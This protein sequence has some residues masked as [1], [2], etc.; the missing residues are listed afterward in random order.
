LDSDR[1]IERVLDKYI[2]SLDNKDKMA[3]SITIVFCDDFYY[4][5]KLEDIKSILYWWA[6]I[7]GF[8]IVRRDS[9]PKG[10]PIYVVIKYKRGGK[11]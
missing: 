3:E 7:E 2:K 8:I 1:H 6:Y 10:N 11:Y 9:K 5:N 4:F